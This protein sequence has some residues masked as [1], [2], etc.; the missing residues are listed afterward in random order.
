MGVLETK[1][2]K[3]DLETLIEA[4]GD[5][6]SIGNHE[7]H[8]MNAIKN[9]PMPPEDHEAFEHV[10]HIKKWYEDRSKEIKTQR[11]V[12]QE[13]AIFLKAKL[14]LLRQDMTIDQLFEI[15]TTNEDSAP[16]SDP[17]MMTKLELAEF[18][19]KDLGVWDQYQKFLEE[20]QT[21]SESGS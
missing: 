12:R 11:R 20:K 13:K 8:I 19:L 7:F 1:F 6:E 5:W 15:T 21:A 16:Q 9:M 14:M 17:G 18:Y 10:V 4:M 2:T 3:D